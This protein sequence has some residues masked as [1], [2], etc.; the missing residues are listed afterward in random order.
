MKPWILAL[1]LGL[2]ASAQAAES[3][4]LFGPPATGS[5]LRRVIVDN[6]PIPFDKGFAELTAAQQSWVKSQY[7]SLMPNDTPPFPKGGL[8]KLYQA[9]AYAAD[10]IYAG[11]YLFMVARVN[12]QGKAEMVQVYN[13][14]DQ[15]VSH[16][17]GLMLMLQDYTPATC[18][19]EPC[20]MEFPFRLEV[21]KSGLYPNVL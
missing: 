3:Y 18:N 6:Y 1:L 11:G 5:N 12:A 19:G 8:A 17:V 7:T 20:A 15:L 21:S 4:T 14:P 10:R 2:S 9:A 16:Y 13:T